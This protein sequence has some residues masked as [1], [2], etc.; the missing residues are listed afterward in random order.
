MT[1]FKD[2]TKAYPYRASDPGSCPAMWYRN[3]E[4]CFIRKAASNMHPIQAMGYLA[5][6]EAQELSWDIGGRRNGLVVIASVK[7]NRFEIGVSTIDVSSMKFRYDLWHK[8]PGD[9]WASPVSMLETRQE[10]IDMI[11][12]IVSGS[13]FIPLPDSRVD[14]VQI[15]PG[16]RQ[17]NHILRQLNHAIS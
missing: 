13:K 12:Q 2:L 4:I 9:N 8:A 14:P 10:V 1:T 11:E 16:L 6:L 7:G 17:A 3:A 15:P 5:A